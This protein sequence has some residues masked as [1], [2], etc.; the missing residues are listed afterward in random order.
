MPWKPQVSICFYHIGIL[1]L[2][3]SLLLCHLSNIESF[4]IKDINAARLK[5]V[6]Q[7]VF[8]DQQHHLSGVAFLSIQLDEHIRVRTAAGDAARLHYNFIV[9][10]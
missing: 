5:V 6:A 1:L 7:V 9:D 8:G 3:N 2:K 4:H 10:V